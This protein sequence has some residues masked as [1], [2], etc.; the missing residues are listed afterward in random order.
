MRTWLTDMQFGMRMLM[1]SPG[2]AVMAILTLAIGIGANTAIFT[3]LNSVLLR[4]LPFH[5]PDRLML[6]SERSPQFDSMSVA[7]QNYQDWK[8]QSTTFE[9]MALFR[10]KSYTL[11][12]NRG[13]EQIT[14]RE[15][16]AGFFD[17]LGVHLAMGREFNSDDDRDGAAPVVVLSYG[18]WQ[19]RFGSGQ[20]VLGKV[21]HLNDQN[22]TVIGVA[23]RDFWFYSKS[24][25]FLPIG[26]TGQI[27]LKTRME[28]EGARALGRLKDGASI[29]NARAELDGI[30]RQLAAAYPEANAG[31]SV[32][33]VPML[34]DVVSDSK[35][36]L[37][38]IALGVGLLLIIACVNVANLLLSRVVP[39]Q[40]EIAI[41]TALGASRHRVASQLLAESVVLALLGGML[42]I[43]F[44]WAGTKGL[45]AAVPNSLPRAETIGMDWR[46]AVF[47][48]LVCVGTGILFG[49]APVWQ[50]LRG[51]MN[52]T[53]KESARGSSGKRHVLQ[54]ALVVIELAIAVLLLVGAGLTVR[55]LAKLAKIDPG[56]Q[57]NHVLT[58]DIG[59][60]K[61]RYDQPQ[62]I[63]NLLHEVITRLQ[64]IPGVEAAA[65]TTD[66]MMRDESE[67]M[68]YVSERPKPDPKD[69]NWSMMYITSPEYLKT[70][71]IRQIRG[72]FFNDHDD[73]GSPGVIVVDEELARTLFPNQD[74]IGQ[75]L[76]IPFPGFDQPREIVGIV[77]HVNH[78]GLA[79]DAT[80]KIRS[81]F[82]IPFGQIPDK[83]YSLVT[84]MTYAV[85][86]N[87]DER[88]VTTAVQQKLRTLDGDIP[89]YNISTMDE[90]ISMSIAQKRFL[91]V[92]LVFFGMAA[93]MLGAVGTYGVI[94]YSVSQ[95]TNEMGIRLALGAQAHNILGMVLGQGAKLIA[96]GVGFGLAVALLASRFMASFVFGVT[97]TDP[98][99]F[100]GV[101]LLLLCVAIAACYVPAR[102][103]TKVDPLI[104]LRYE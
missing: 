30:G 72:R 25:L 76:V 96:I 27:W 7:Y 83:L 37:G 87:L 48:L 46:V 39:R 12:G 50:V 92:L 86:S 75:H 6:M 44:A 80:A 78:W 74:P 11:T 94:S 52:Q 104:A 16:S 42:G 10:Q 62:K 66:L 4:P 63:R 88:A 19:R 102:R 49:L 29:A 68:F 91:S 38:L 31:H 99:T 43:G 84:G 35:G 65:T 24:D 1:K 47:L 85:R 8:R 101:A 90:I 9:K 98:V 64:D 71:S 95:R 67:T 69:Y 26:G 81:E 54:N 73:Q 20:D 21:V 14:A 13:P 23:P 15:V 61:L 60:S 100:G 34:D 45:L 32:G 82:Y 3:V 36:T 103:A 57:A 77:R 40:R 58:F 97:A 33:I 28:R 59:F 5:D 2:F 93:L 51:D 17:L 41:R 18:L 53:L 79:E 89:V 70:M 55:T 56:F 22:Y